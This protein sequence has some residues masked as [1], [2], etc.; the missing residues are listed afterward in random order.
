MLFLAGMIPKEL[1]RRSKSSFGKRS[2]AEGL[3]NAVVMA[4]CTSD[5]FTKSKEAENDPYLERTV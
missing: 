5:H 3:S 2:I 4:S 1:M